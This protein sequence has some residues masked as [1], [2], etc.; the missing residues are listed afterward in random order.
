MEDLQAYLGACLG[1]E[2]EVITDPSLA[3]GPMIVVGAGPTARSLGVDPNPDT[4]G[5]QGYVLRTVPPHIVIAGGR[6][7]GTLYGVHRFLEDYFGVRWFAPGVTRTPNVVSV[8]VPPTDEMVQPGFFFRDIAYTWPGADDDF[9][10]RRAENSGNGDENSPT[11]IR[12]AHDGRCH[13][14]FWFISPEEFYDEHLEYF[15]LVGGVRLRDET[16]LCLTNPD[17]LEIVTERMLQRMADRPE[18]Q[19]HN[20]SQMDWYNYCEC[21]N[22]RRINEQ[23]GTTGGTQFWFV[24]QLA[25]R[26][27]QVYPD[28]LISTLAYTY[29][30]EPPV[31]MTMHPNVAVWLCHMYP[32]CDAHP[33]ATCPLNAEYR[34]RAEAWAGI[35]NH[36]QEKSAACCGTSECCASMTRTR[37]REGM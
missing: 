24:N 6:A 2:P 35:T 13:T 11:G 21:E 19:Q 1:V 28:K 15:S 27:A 16:Q 36:L 31:G 20:F 3:D 4:L 25:E 32:S 37:T 23:Y 12:Y 30:E 18:V 34:R 22:C 7:V 8:T 5:D 14:Y 17:V 9:L 10:V 33:V 29:T 26:V